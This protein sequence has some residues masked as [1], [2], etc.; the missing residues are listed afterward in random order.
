MR[1]IIWTIIAVWVIWRV[2]DAF[3]MYSQKTQKV[4]TN[5]TDS[6]Y[7]NPNQGDNASTYNEPSKK[8]HLKADAGEYVDYEETK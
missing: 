3:K 6:K 7:T 8:G 5:T 2:I 1:D 4:N